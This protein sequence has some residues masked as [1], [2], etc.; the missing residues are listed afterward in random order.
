MTARYHAPRLLAIAVLLTPLPAFAHH[1]MDGEMPR[2]FLQGFLSGLGHPVIGWDHLAAIVGVG[3][4]AAIA[5]RGVPPVLAFSA[6]MIGGVVVHLLSLDLPAGELL[7]GLSTLAIGVLVLLRLSLG[8]LPLAAVFALAGLAHGYALGESIVGAEPTPLGAYLAGLL[9][10]Q[11]AVATGAY[12]A[13]RGLIAANPN[14]RPVA[15]S[16]LGAAI[17]LAGGIASATASGL[18]G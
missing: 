13:I 6:A 12:A 15:L 7:V 9:I 3:L 4:L 5:A 11:T 8:F 18:L 16:L 14:L 10:I 1:V 17:V 2:T